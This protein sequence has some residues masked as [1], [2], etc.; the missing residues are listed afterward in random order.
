MALE[1]FVIMPQP[2][3]GD[4]TDDLNSMVATATAIVTAF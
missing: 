3:Q 4:T 2:M 1:I